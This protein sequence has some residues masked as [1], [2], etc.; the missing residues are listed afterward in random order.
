MV[1]T[2]YQPTSLPE[3]DPE[4]LLGDLLRGLGISNAF[5]LGLIALAFVLKTWLDA[6]EHANKAFEVALGVKQFLERSPALRTPIALALTAVVLF[7]QTCT[8]L[9]AYVIGNFISILSAYGE[10]GNPDPIAEA[11]WQVMSDAWS[12]SGPLGIFSANNLTSLQLD[13]VSGT[14]LALAL[15]V[16]VLAYGRYPYVAS[17]LDKGLWIWGGFLSFPLS[18]ASPLF[19]LAGGVAVTRALAGDYQLTSDD[20]ATLA[21]AVVCTLYWTTCSAAIAGASYVASTW[22]TPQQ[23]S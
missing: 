8:L 6:L 12:S 22:R 19:I 3:Y 1:P 17:F 7:A 9:I 18:L 16:L 5:I 15:G 10:I 21:A 23:I 4:D 11:R 13:G 20:R 2:W 14:Y